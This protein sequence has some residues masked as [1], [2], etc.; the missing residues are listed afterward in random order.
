METDFEYAVRMTLKEEGVFSNHSWDPGRATKYGVTQA[1]W[2]AFR[3][4]HGAVCP[5]DV[6]EI[7]VIQARA[8]YHDL[9]NDLDL[10]LILNKHVAA[11]IFDSA[12]NCG[13]RRAVQFAQRACNFLRKPHMAALRVDGILGR[14]S[15]AVI[16]YY[17][18]NGYTVNLLHA[19]NGEQYRW[20]AVGITNE[21]LK[22]HAGRGWMRRL[23]VFHDTGV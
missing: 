4:R 8:V 18:R 14:Q 5:S 7:S 9:W 1:A 22:R 21:T 23:R 16:A 20:Y 10:G 2:D 19:L 6:A 17:L 11:E 3:G 15:R 13:P 12:V